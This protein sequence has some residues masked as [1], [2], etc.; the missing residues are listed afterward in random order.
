MCPARLWYN[1]REHTESA[2]DRCQKPETRYMDKLRGG[3][4][5]GTGEGNRHN[6]KYKTY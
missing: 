3:W 1:V 6:Q 5:G 2:K 4:D